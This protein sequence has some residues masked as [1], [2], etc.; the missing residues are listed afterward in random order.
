MTVGRVVALILATRHAEAPSDP[1]ARWLVDIDLGILGADPEAYRR[2]ETA[3]RREYR[4][5]PG[6]LFRRKRA[7]LLEGFLA[8]PRLYLTDHFHARLEAPARRNLADA[9]RQLRKS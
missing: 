5:V 7:E 6:L 2:Y 3:I 1:D 4:L 8:R 9:V